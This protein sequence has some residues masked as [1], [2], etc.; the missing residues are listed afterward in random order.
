M[1][2]ILQCVPPKNAEDGLGSS[3]PDSCLEEDMVQ[4]NLLSEDESDHWIL[5][6]LQEWFSKKKCWSIYDVTKNVPKEWKTR[7]SSLCSF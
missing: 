2:T 3:S 1:C 5:L 4:W 6:R 7:I